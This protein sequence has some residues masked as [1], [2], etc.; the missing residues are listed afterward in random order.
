MANLRSDRVM[1]ALRDFTVAENPGVQ[2]AG[3][4][5]D[6]AA[7]GGLLALET[8]AEIWRAAGLQMIEVEPEVGSEAARLALT[9]AHCGRRLAL[10]PVGGPW[11]LQSGTG[12]R[13]PCQP[14]ERRPVCVSPN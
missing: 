12:L 5:L 3:P 6:D 9:C 14:G 7:E 11:S 4:D 2:I 1:Q 8:A 10:G 13:C